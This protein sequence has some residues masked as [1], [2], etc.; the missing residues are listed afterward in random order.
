MDPFVLLRYPLL[1]LRW[2]LDRIGL[3][4]LLVGLAGGT[5]LAVILNYT[6]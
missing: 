3:R 1:V 4:W 6:T 2:W 5:M